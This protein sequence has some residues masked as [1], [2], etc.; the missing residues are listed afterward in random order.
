M[1]A[2]GYAIRVFAFIDLIPAGAGG[3]AL[4]QMQANVPGGGA[5]L[6]PHTTGIAQTLAMTPVF[7]QVPGG[8]APSGANFQTA[9]NSAAADLYTNLTAA[10]LAQVQAFAT[11]GA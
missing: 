8:A 9:L 2:C 10:Q 4:G 3:A 7:E 6:I 5:T 1:A 11:G